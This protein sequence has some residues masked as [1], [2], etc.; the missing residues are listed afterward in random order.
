MKNNYAITLENELGEVYTYDCVS[1]HKRDAVIAAQKHIKKDKNL[2]NT[3]YIIVDV[4]FVNNSNKVKYV[5]TNTLTET[6]GG[7]V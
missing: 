1:E 4:K 7:T 3:N 2:M 5:N 6:W